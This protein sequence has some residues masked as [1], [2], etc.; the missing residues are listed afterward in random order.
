[1]I[2][3]VAARVCTDE[4]RVYATGFSG[5]RMSSLLAWQLG[6]RRAAGARS[7]HGERTA[8]ESRAGIT[9][10]N[11]IAGL[12]GDGQSMNRSQMVVKAMIGLVVVM[13]AAACTASENAGPATTE[14]AVVLYLQNA[15]RQAESPAQ[16]QEIVKALEDLRTL[17]P[18][19]L[20]EQRYADYASTP[21]QWTLT[22]LL[23]K[24]FVPD[25][26]RAI[27]EAA[28]YRDAQAAAARALIEEHLKA[29]R[30]HRQ[31]FKTP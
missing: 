23:Q 3:H 19:R 18:D 21:R 27:D 14:N 17:P 2:A 13:L 31:V 4:A 22:Q 15:E 11:R 5:G 1:V 6:S 16:E 26:P 10:S 24:Y 7:G 29:I 28:F 9:T 25:A 30:E 20:K 12:M 8:V